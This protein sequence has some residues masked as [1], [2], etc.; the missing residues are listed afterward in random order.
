MSSVTQRIKEVTQPRGGYVKLTQFQMKEIDDTRVLSDSE[1]ISASIVGMVVDYLTRFIMEGNVKEAF[2]ISCKGAK[3]AEKNFQQKNYLKRAQSLLANIT[4]LDDDSIMNAC[5][6]VTYDVWFRNPKEAF[7]AKRAEEI[8]PD[9]VTIQNIRVMVERSVAFWDQY[10]PIKKS[11]FSFESKGYT[12]I[13]TQGDG[14]YLT[15]DTL[16]DFKVS[17]SKPNNK[18]TLQL[19][20]YWIMGQHSEQEIYK[21]IHK[22]G[23]FNPRLNRVYIL[24]VENIEKK[25]IK[26]VEDEVIG[27]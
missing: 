22:L 19:L 2:E 15:D 21:N 14:D 10:G 27:Y 18:N 12:E 7:R 17:K 3:I 13:V 4:G 23:I 20:M 16:W 1:N 11:G 26:I 9:A 25:V 5:K 24:D 8:K 6:L